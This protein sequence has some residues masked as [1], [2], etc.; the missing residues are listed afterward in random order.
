MIERIDYAEIA[1]DALEAIQ[2]AGQGMV[3]F[4]AGEPGHYDEIEDEYI[5]GTPDEAIP[6][7]GVFGD[8]T[9]AYAAKAGGS[10]QL[11]DRMIYAEAV[12]IEPK[13]TDHVYI[14]GEEWS[15]VNITPIS[16]AGI[17]VLYELHIR[18]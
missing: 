5:D 18:P 8:V 10:I 15:I 14:M 4:S 11:R 2:E 1:A 12:S 17:D 16:P 6:F 3:L 9:Y 13:L 7:F